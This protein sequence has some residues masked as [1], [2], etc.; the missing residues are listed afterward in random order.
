MFVFVIAGNL[1]L[2]VDLTGG[3]TSETEIEEARKKNNG[4]K[5][6]DRNEMKNTS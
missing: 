5:Y 3:G 6:V 2:P 1:S 4:V